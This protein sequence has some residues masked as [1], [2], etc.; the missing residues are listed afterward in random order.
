M[1]GGVT[2]YTKRVCQRVEGGVKT[3]TERVCQRVEGVLQLIQ[4]L[5]KSGG[6]FTAYAE[7]LCQRVEGGVLQLTQRESLSNCKR[8]T[9]RES[10][11][12]EDM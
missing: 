10:G 1:E 6:G 9:K 3:H 4:S 7:R 8:K 2:A 12:D 11:K 5:S